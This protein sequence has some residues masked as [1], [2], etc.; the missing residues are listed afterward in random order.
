[1]RFLTNMFGIRL[2]KYNLYFCYCGK[3]K[4]NTKNKNCISCVIFNWEQY[5]LK[6][7]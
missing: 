2:L 7:L 6:P 3:I 5:Y 1:M 4:L